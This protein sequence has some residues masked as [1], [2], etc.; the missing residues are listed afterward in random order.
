MPI[1]A[2]YFAVLNHSD[3]IDGIGRGRSLMP[4]SA[5]I[6]CIVD[7][8][9]ADATLQMSDREPSILVGRDLE[10]RVSRCDGDCD[11]DDRISGDVDKLPVQNSASGQFNVF[12]RR[13]L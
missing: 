6:R 1:T 13:W 4:E 3:G 12:Q 9:D 8:N 7:F 5:S 10:N 2:D 11:C